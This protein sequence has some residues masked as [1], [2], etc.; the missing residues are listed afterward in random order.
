M[1][2]SSCLLMAF[3]HV[4]F[5]QAFFVK[6]LR[7]LSVHMKSSSEFSIVRL[8][9]YDM[10]KLMLLASNEFR[11]NCNNINDLIILHYSIVTLFGTKFL[12]PDRMA[13]SLIGIK[14]NSTNELVGFV[15]LSL[16]VSQSYSIQPS[17]F[18]YLPLD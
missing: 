10:P 18:I 17:Y 12:F 6:P 15:D 4:N 11:K 8:K 5:S 7:P 1:W 16:Q 3:L 14:L 2:S 13:H 9:V